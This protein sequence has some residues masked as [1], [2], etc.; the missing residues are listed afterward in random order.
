MRFIYKVLQSH[1]RLILWLDS[2]ILNYLPASACGEILA[3]V[4]LHAGKFFYFQV[5][6]I[7]RAARCAVFGLSSVANFS[8]SI[9]DLCMETFPNKV[10]Q[11]ILFCT[12]KS[13]PTKKYTTVSTENSF[14]MILIYIYIRYG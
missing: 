7:M 3:C 12:S 10:L 9:L 4:L 2:S 8:L 11:K 6:L 14:L 13:Y 5:L 1:T